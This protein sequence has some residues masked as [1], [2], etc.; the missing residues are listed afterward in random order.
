MATTAIKMLAS[1]AISARAAAVNVPSP[2]ISVCRLDL[3]NT[4]CEGC[5]RT[6][7]EIRIW[8]S[9]T[10]AEKKSIWTRIERRMLTA[11]QIDT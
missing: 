7:E 1:R 4:H 10:D 11:A 6:L 5:L 8:S 2:C 9:S 3:G